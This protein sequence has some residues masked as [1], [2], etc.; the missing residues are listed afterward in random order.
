M[1]CALLANIFIVILITYSV[2]KSKE[3]KIEFA[4]QLKF[5]AFVYFLFLAIALLSIKANQVDPLN[6]SLGTDMI[7]ISSEILAVIL[8]YLFF[9]KTETLKKVLD[10]FAVKSKKHIWLSV[11]VYILL[12]IVAVGSL[13]LLY[14][15]LLVFRV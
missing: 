5:G 14:E 2:W 12:C 15:W 11:F 7:F 1:F 13:I 9:F 10:P 8:L 3:G 4:K 6:N